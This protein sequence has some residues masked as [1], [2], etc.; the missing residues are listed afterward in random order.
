MKKICLLTLIFAFLF[1]QS[2]FSQ[3]AVTGTVTDK[4]TGDPLQGVSVVEKET[5]NGTIT[6]QHGNF[7]LFVTNPKRTLVFTCIGYNTLEVKLKGKTKLKVKLMATQ[8]IL[9][10]DVSEVSEEYVA[11]KEYKIRESNKRDNRSKS[12]KKI[13]SNTR[14]STS[15]VKK[16]SE[17]KG[18]YSPQG[19]VKLNDYKKLEE[20][21]TGSESYAKITENGFKLVD[22][23]PLSTFSV[24]VDRAAYSNVRRFIN[25]GQKP[26]A[27]AVRIE[28]MVNYFHYDYPEPKSEHPIEIYTELSVCPWQSKHQLLHVGMQGKKNR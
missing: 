7:R 4:N 6:D 5:G 12:T 3:T 28:E 16:S 25:S 23:S 11:P 18:G 15:V 1:V 26:P 17:K 21:V 9:V 8:L 22:A 13:F 14:K 27:D 20:P 10:D 24:D 19:F 2:S